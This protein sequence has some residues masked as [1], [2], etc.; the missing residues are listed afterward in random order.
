MAGGTHRFRCFAPVDPSRVWLA[1]TDGQKTSKYLYG[2]VADSSWT[3]GAPI[4]FRAARSQPEGQST[5]T[6]RVLCAQTHRRLSYFL[7]SG[8][9]DPSTYFTW[10]IRSCPGGSTV[11]LQVDQA[12]CTDTEEEAENTWLPVL[13][14]LHLCFPETSPHDLRNPARDSLPRSRSELSATAFQERSAMRLSVDDAPQGQ[15]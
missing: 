4:H 6:G 2:L 5:L 13:A 8:P 10:Q 14:A 15:V 9:N 1:L 3:A 11:H 7:R 12:E